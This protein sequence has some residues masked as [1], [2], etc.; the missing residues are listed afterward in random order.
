MKIIDET[1]LED[2]CICVQDVLYEL[3]QIFMRYPVDF[4][5]VDNA[6]E[7]ELEE[8]KIQQELSSRIAQDANV[9]TF[10]DNNNEFLNCR[11]ETDVLIHSFNKRDSE[12]EFM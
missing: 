10:L 4:Y 2:F 6:D 3:M 9:Q 12:Y 1:C 8:I 5:D 7:I 11:D